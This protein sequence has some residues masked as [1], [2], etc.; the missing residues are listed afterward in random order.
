MTRRNLGMA[1]LSR[2]IVA[3]P[4]LDAVAVGKRHLPHEREVG[5]VL[6]VVT[7]DRDRLA[8]AEVGPRDARAAFA[9]I[10][11]QGR[12]VARKA[13]QG[14]HAFLQRTF[15][16]ALDDQDLADLTRIMARLTAS[17]QLTQPTHDRPSSPP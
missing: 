10:T 3:E 14:H 15:G 16:D 5:R 9:T 11:P 1:L 17:A 6:G 4:E 13:R 2:L 7:A 8:L 12:S